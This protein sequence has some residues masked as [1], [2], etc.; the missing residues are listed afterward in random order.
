MNYFLLLVF[1]WSVYAGAATLP[2]PDAPVYNSNCTYTTI[3]RRF[4]G[5]GMPWLPVNVYSD[6]RPDTLI[7]EKDQGHPLSLV[8]ET[9]CNESVT[10]IFPNQHLSFI[11]FETIIGEQRDFFIFLY[12]KV[13]YIPEHVR[14]VVAGPGRSGGVRFEPQPAET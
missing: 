14:E 11:Q 5:L 2:F 12:T 8:T 10:G 1:Q 13:H 6:V 9:Q 4:Q 3:V 7:V